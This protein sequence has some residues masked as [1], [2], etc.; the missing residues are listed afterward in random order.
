MSRWIGPAAHLSRVVGVAA[1]QRNELIG[2][3]RTRCR[4][5]LRFRSEG[6]LRGPT[7]LHAAAQFAALLTLFVFLSVGCSRAAQPQAGAPQPVAQPQTKPAPPTPIAIKKV[8]LG[9]GD[10]WNP[11]WDLMIEKALPRNLV[12]RRRAPAVRALC[13]RYRTMTI[14]NRRAFWAYFF[15]ALAGAE[16]GLRPTADVRHTEPQ[17]AVIDPVTHRIA[18]QE[19]LL[20]LA[21]ADSERYGCDFDWRRDKDLPEHDRAKTILEPRNNLLCGIRIVENQLINQHKPLLTNSSYWVTLR[22]DSP[23]FKI[24]LRQMADVPEACGSRL[25]KPVTEQTLPSVDEADQAQ[26]PVEAE[27]AEPVESRTDS[28]ADPPAKP[29]SSSH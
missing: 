23:S 18:R 29:F 4:S 15:Q 25:R 8:E 21:Y 12:T 6:N 16:A 26:S 10:P 14:A 13:P 1:S 20:Q 7:R 19:G 22:P 28:T 27:P 5:S 2:E 11:A 24:F 17:V 9:E 3:E